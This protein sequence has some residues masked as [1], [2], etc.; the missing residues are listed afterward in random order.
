MHGCPAA[1]HKIVETAIV[2]KALTVTLNHEPGHC[3]ARHGWP[4]LGPD[5]DRADEAPDVCRESSVEYPLVAIKPVTEQH[6]CH[7]HTD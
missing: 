6:R 1:L 4:T 5:T 3:A 7:H 2:T